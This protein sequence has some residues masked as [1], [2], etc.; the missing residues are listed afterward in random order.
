MSATNTPASLISKEQL[1]S[2]LHPFFPQKGGLLPDLGEQISKL[3]ASLTAIVNCQDDET[4]KFTISDSTITWGL[5]AA[6]DILEEARLRT[7]VFQD[8][9]SGVWRELNRRL[10]QCDIVH[11]EESGQ[12]VPGVH[13]VQS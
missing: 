8:N 7:E 3:E 12:A 13:G 10:D 6:L 9:V 11:R 4:G 5:L 1:L 2:D